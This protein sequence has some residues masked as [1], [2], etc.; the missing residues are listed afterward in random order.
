MGRIS[1][2]VLGGFSGK[3]GNVVGGSWK[4]IDYM[5]IKPSSVANPKTVGQVDQR[6]KFTA[7]L[8]FLQPLK[9]FVKVG[10]KN[11]ANKMTEFNSAMSYTLG[12]AITGVSPDFLVDYSTALLSRGSLP[13]ALNPEVEST[14]AGSVEVTW[15][16]NTLNGTAA[17]TDKSLIALYNPNKAEAIYTLEGAARSI[18]TQNLVVPTNYSGDDLEA[19]I[20]FQSADGTSVSNSIYIGSVTVA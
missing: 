20:S 2:G 7:A 6:T 18:G 8:Q 19:Y 13:G 1:K 10:Y 12:N 14:V 3:I 5:R 17:A 9:D 16:D 4:G 11:H 15:D